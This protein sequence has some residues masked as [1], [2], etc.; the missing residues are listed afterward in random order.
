MEFRL[1]LLLEYLIDYVSVN[2]LWEA[3]GKSSWPLFEVSIFNGASCRMK[4]NIAIYCP[5]QQTPFPLT[6]SA[7]INGSGQG[8]F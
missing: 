4:G 7:E 1:I 8:I 2:P 6:H 5:D 3:E